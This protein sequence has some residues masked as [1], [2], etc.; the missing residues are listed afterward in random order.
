MNTYTPSP[1]T[2]E[3]IDILSQKLEQAI[4]DGKLT[5]SLSF[6]TEALVNIQANNIKVLHT[7]PGDEA[8]NMTAILAL[9]EF[10]KYVKLVCQRFGLTLNVD[11]TLSED[12]KSLAV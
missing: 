5:V 11:G 9:P 1:E 7:I 3:R 6:K 10:N 4:D 2:R 8:G 12:T